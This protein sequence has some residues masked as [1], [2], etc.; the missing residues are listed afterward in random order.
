[1]NA[2]RAAAVSGLFYPDDALQLGK[3]V[4]NY[5]NQAV[6]S[7][8][9]GEVS[10]RAL[11]APHAGYIYSAPIAAS[12]Y[13][14]IQGMA[15]KIRRVVLLGPS[16]YVGFQGLA[17]SSM[18]YYHTPLGRVRLDQ[19]VQESLLKLPQVQVLDAAHAQEHSLEVQLPFL[20]ILL[21]DFSLLPVV[22]G[23][24]T[25]E[26]VA[27]VLEQFQDDNQTLIIVST[28]LSHYL[29]YQSACRI[30]RYTSQ[31]IEN[32][33]S[34]TIDYHMACGKNPLNGLLYWAKQKGLQA[35]TLDLR[36]SGDTAGSK[37]KVVGYGAY[38][39][40]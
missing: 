12:A 36:N 29:D 37:D 24:A 22:V 21:P 32:L 10:P 16:H 23:D 34:E 6:A 3:E 31:Q 2:I 28:D 25:K 1:M 4:E 35:Q 40:A 26:S 15:D 7:A 14:Q 18:Q 27:Q 8:S 33:H 38:I 5:L 13:I 9:E 20:Q 11:V 17:L 39:L 30:D 19:R